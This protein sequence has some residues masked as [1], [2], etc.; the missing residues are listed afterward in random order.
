MS[1]NENRVPLSL[2][3]EQLLKFLFD[4][5]TP[6]SDSEQTM[7]TFS[8]DKKRYLDALESLKF[9]KYIDIQYADD[10]PFDIWITNKGRELVKNNLR[11]SLQQSSNI[12]IE[13]PIRNQV[14]ISY[15]HKDKRWLERLQTHLKPL[16]RDGLI[17][18]WDDTMIDSGGDWRKEIRKAITS[19]KVAVLL[20]TADF[21]ASDFIANNELPPLLKAAEA[22]GAVILPLIVSS[23]RFE[24]TES[25]SKFQA[26][27][28][29][30]RPLD[31]MKLGQREEIFVKLTTDIEKVLKQSADSLSFVTIPISSSS[32][33]L[34]NEDLSIYAHPPYGQQKFGKIP[35]YVEN[36]RISMAD[37]FDGN[38]ITFNLQKPI[39]GV[40]AVHFLINAGDGRKRY[41]EVV[42]GR[43][44]FIFKDDSLSPQRFE[45]KLIQN[46]REWA[47]G[48]YVT[49]TIDGQK[50]YDPLVDSV[51]GN[52]ISY[53]AW[54]G[55][56]S[57]GQVAV[58][59][60]LQVGIDESKHDKAL[61]SIRF[62]RD[63][64]RGK[65]ALDYFVS[66]IT[67]EIGNAK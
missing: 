34:V 54:R 60:M 44:E 46:V 57:T 36:A 18:R 64:P 45:I 52:Q 2:D 33:S 50:K 35:F 49:V 26:V 22:D 47:I 59:D 1:N 40:H 19:T 23:S 6:A 15:S 4:S 8:W 21:L 30:S 14:F 58:M 65:Y 7:N 63:I 32:P 56:T 62:T 53:E 20:I 17:V 51:K 31:K 3:A 29:P 67:V 24:Y 41:G 12:N 5:S 66:G 37:V 11:S 25:L 9:K 48:N 16:E 13:N 55:T 43:I 28:S 38:G 27:N 39:I 42:I 10:K 61:T